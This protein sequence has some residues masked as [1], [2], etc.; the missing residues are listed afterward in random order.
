MPT[1][2]PEDDGARR[3]A[4]PSP[5]PGRQWRARITPAVFTDLAIWM[6]GFGVVIGLVFP[7]FVVALGV[8]AAEVL[9]GRFF[10][11]TLLA[12]LVVGGVNWLLARLVVG[13]RLRLLSGRMQHVASAIRHAAETGDWT[14]CDEDRCRLAVDSE[15]E[16]GDCA[17]AF[18]ELIGALG[19]SQRV[20]AAIRD[21]FQTL[22]SHL[23]LKQLADAALAWVAGHVGASAGALF[24]HQAGTLDL[25]GTHGSLEPS[26]MWSTPELQEA[27]KAHAPR[28]L[29]S[30]RSPGSQPAWAVPIFFADQPLGLVVL[31][32]RTV[33]SADCKR[34]LELFSRAVAVSL[35]NALTHA[36]SQDLARLDPLTGCVNRRLGFAQLDEALADPDSERAG[37]G[38]LMIDLDHFKRV[39]DTRGHLGGDRV[40]V[41]AAMT[42]ASCLRSTDTLAR[43][44]G[45][46]FLAILPGATEDALTRVAER[47]CAALHASSV[48][49]GGHEI[50]VTASVGVVRY[51]H[52]DIRTSAQVLELADKA[53][54]RA[55]AAGRN[56]VV[57]TYRDHEED[58][59][60]SFS[61]G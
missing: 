51:P 17:R 8:D 29:E 20:E 25:V 58:R 44:G 53:L 6:V 60:Q 35:V 3:E 39:N 9:T 55:K 54:Y 61:P 38:V 27:M 21:L 31:T 40:L 45:E 50:R 10:V 49:Y 15:D 56:R 30:S 59:P 7:Y 4:E 28:V 33:L 1:T 42:I 26:D 43:Y 12:G 2:V 47:V 5:R 32:G 13:A 24:L 48:E 41:H 37:V 23:E 34:V 52:A 11:S 36:R 46:E 22:S 14:G 18:N 19:R 16:L 57:S